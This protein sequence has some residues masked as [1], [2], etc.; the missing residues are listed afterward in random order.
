MS[1]SVK[2]AF[3]KVGS[4]CLTLFVV[5]CSWP[6]KYPRRTSDDVQERRQGIEIEESET[7]SE[8]SGGG[9]KQGVPYG[10]VGC[11]TQV[12]AKSAGAGRH[13]RFWI[14]LGMVREL[15]ITL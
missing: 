8:T 9:T 6:S 14:R 15:S 4:V 5:H 2:R 3:L 10:R 13:E 7:A 1:C 12:D 11:Q